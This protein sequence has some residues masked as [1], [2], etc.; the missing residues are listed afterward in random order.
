[1]KFQNVLRDKLNESDTG[2]Y[3]DSSDYDRKQK[4]KPKNKKLLLKSNQKENSNKEN[5]KVGKNYE[6][7]PPSK[8][9]THHEYQPQTKN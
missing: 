5:I 3:D 1:M 2:S 7:N 4:K 6:P 8:L 9:Y